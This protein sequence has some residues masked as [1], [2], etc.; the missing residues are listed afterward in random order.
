MGMNRYT[1]VGTCVAGIASATC[2]KPIQRCL[3]YSL[4]YVNYCWAYFCLH[5]CY[6][7]KKFSI[8]KQNFNFLF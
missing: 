7:F 4:V 6:F 2:R 5:G 8:N 1:K 3:I